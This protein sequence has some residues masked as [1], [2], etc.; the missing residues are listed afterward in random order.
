[1]FTPSQVE[2]STERSEKEEEER[3][4]PAPSP[5]GYVRQG[6]GS[7]SDRGSTSRSS[8][9]TVEQD[10]RRPATARKRRRGNA[11]ESS[12][13]TAPSSETIAAL[14]L[15]P[16]AKRVKEQ[17]QLTPPLAVPGARLW[18]VFAGRDR[19]GSL[20]RAAEMLGV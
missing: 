10:R 14:G 20:G 8:R 19:P 11:E 5:A 1:M 7:C 16:V 9:L 12:R 2:R 3:Q 13:E 17:T 15:D 4:E 6:K 18:H